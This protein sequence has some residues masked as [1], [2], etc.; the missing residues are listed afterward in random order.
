M[1]SMKILK[2]VFLILVVFLTLSCQKEEIKPK[3]D[4][5][6]YNDSTSQDI[7]S[8]LVDKDWVLV[9]GNFYYEDPQIYFNHPENSYLN[10]FYGPDCQFDYFDVGIT[11]WR[12]NITQFFLNGVLQSSEPNSGG[13][14]N[15]FIYVGVD[16]GP[17]IITRTIEVINITSDRL[18]VKVGQ[19][20]TLLGNPYSILVFRSTTSITNQNPYVPF[21][22]QYQGVLTIEGNNPN[23]SIDDLYGTKWVVTKFYNG[24][25]YDQP[26]DTLEFLTNG[27][28]SINGSINNNRTYNVNTIVGN[29]S[30]NLNLNDFITMGGN[31]YS[32]LTSNNFI[33][34]GII[35]GSQIEDILN[36][37]NSIKFIWMERIQ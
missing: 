14:N 25:G 17:N 27:Q 8:L 36:P 33:D 34:D 9:S 15:Q 10:P 23:L 7:I 3:P 6:N 35:N 4:N 26:N 31:N 2:I 24:F 13:I 5:N 37:N 29:T 11:T 22:Y 18:E 1:K 32:I 19:I 12:F 21:N 20:G 16:N 28:Y 30:V